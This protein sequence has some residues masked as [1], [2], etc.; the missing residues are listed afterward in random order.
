MRLLLTGA[1]GFI[2]R[3]V[4]RSLPADFEVVAVHCHST[5]LIDYARRWARCRVRVLRADLTTAEGV[6]TVARIASRYDAGLLLAGNGDPAVSMDRPG[7]D[8]I[9]N[10]HSVVQLLERVRFGTL[11]F[12]SSGAVYD[13]LVGPVTP[14][15]S[16]APVLPY[17]ISKLAAERYLEHFRRRGRMDRLFIIRFFGAYGPLEPQ[18]KIYGRLVKRFAMEKEPHFTLRGDGTNLIDAMYIDD[19]VRAIGLLLDAPGEGGTYDLASGNPLTLSELVREA[20]ATFGQ[21]PVIRY[22]GEVPECIQFYSADSALWTRFGFT[23][24]VGLEEGLRRFAAHLAAV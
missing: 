21:A 8:L 2:G 10:A 4:L 5:D 22:E 1:S 19:A 16:L 17:A 9:S 13:K 12:F 18:R 20:A 6:G 7:F 14:V 23:A 3:N 24:E 15:S 11:L